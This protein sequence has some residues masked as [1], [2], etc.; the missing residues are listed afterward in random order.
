MWLIVSV[1]N[2]LFVAATRLVQKSFVNHSDM[3]AFRLNW[4]MFGAGLPLT[5]TIIALQWQAITHLHWQFWLD[6]AAVVC[7]YYPAVS[8]LYIKVIRENELSDVLPLQSVVPVFTA[9]FGWLWLAQDPSWLAFGGL[10]AV[11]VAIYTLYRHPSMPWYQPILALG[12]SAAARAMLVVSLITAAAAVGDKFGIEH[13]SVSIYL[14]LNVTAA[15]II[16][17]ICDMIAVSKQLVRPLRQEIQ[18]LYRSQWLVLVCLGFLQTA[19]I[20]LSFIAVH[21][22]AN[23][24]YT[25]AIRNLNIVVASLAALYLLRE[26]INRYKLLSYGLSA[27]GVVML[28]L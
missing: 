14:A 11:T 15:V 5:I 6:L 9:F 10:I 27:L 13:S 7:G 21:V 20:L 16:L 28:A 23:T 18:G 1:I 4:M 19:S 12:S 25:I 26:H 2:M 17:V 8:Y 24:S 3:N 22:S